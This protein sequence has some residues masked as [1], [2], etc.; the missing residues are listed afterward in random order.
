MTTHVYRPLDVR[1]GSMTSDTERFHRTRIQWR[2]LAAGVAAAGLAL[3][4]FAGAVGADGPAATERYVVQSGDTLWAIAAE[5]TA[6]GDD[7]RQTAAAIADASEL[8]T[9][10][11][12]VGQELLIPIDG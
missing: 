4:L 8:G 5:H 12:S 10:T 7:V 6:P 2:R 9:G 3:V 1:L 11:L